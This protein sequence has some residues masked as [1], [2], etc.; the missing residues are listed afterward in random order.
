MGAF[1][2][3]TGDIRETYRIMNVVTAHVTAPIPAFGQVD[4]PATARR[5]LDMLAI[6]AQRVGA[7][8]VIFI[9][10]LPQWLPGIGGLVMF[11]SGTAVEVTPS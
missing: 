3:S 11:A 6:D 4:V 10:F 5:A 1:Y 2:I 8:G 7:N 9:S